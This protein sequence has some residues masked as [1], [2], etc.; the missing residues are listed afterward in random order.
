[1]TDPPHRPDYPEHASAT[2]TD[3][4]G[5][6]PLAPGDEILVVPMDAPPA[7]EVVQIVMD[8]QREGLRATLGEAAPIPL[9]AHDAA[10][11]Q[12]RAERLL[13]EARGHDAQRRVLGLTARDLFLEGTEWV[14]G[15]AESPGRTAVVSLFRLNQGA[16]P[17]RTRMRVL[18]EAVRLVGRTTGLADCP[19]PRCVMHPAPSVAAVDAK[20]AR[21]CGTCLLHASRRLRR[22]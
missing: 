8:L 19:V 17:D 22:R 6:L 18:K 5:P 15:A 14:F 21:L 12:S 16:D 13:A 3:P 1:M 11:G 20:T 2:R 7:N 9:A 10:R 4:N